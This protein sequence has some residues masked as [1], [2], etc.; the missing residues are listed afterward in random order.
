MLKQCCSDKSEVV[1]KEK[2]NNPNVKNS[3]IYY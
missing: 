2:N 1:Y 3:K